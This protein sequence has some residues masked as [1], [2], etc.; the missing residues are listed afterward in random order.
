MA[1]PDLVLRSGGVHHAEANGQPVNG[2][3]TFA[4]AIPPAIVEEDFLDVEVEFDGSSITGVSNPVVSPDKTQ[5]SL[6]FVQ[7]GTDTCTVRAVQ[8]HSITW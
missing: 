2:V 7:T 3:N 5:L 4:L 8:N 1:F 6:N